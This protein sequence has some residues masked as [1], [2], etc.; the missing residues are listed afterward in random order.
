MLCE[1]PLASDAAEAQQMVDAFQQRDVLLAEAFMYR[2][3]PQIDR[4]KQ[5][6]A[7]GAVGQMQVMQGVF[8]FAISDE[9]NVRL[10]KELIGGALMDVGCYPVSLIRY[11]SG[12]EP[13][14]VSA[15][16][17]FGA[18]SGVDETLVGLLRFPGGVLAHFD[19]SLRAE[20]ANTFEVRGSTGR[21]LLERAYTPF[22]PDPNVASTI[23]YWH[24]GD[25][26]EIVIPPT[27][28]Y[29]LMAEDFADAL[30]NQRP[31]RF[32]IA[33]SIA[34]MRTL[35]QLYAAAGRQ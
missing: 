33:D 31:P 2:F 6:I 19:C 1:K 20:T 35:D 8:S 3:H 18:Q 26:E 34:Q 15:M 5:M 27:D 30:L 16:A 21:I 17:N 14:E 13:S 7:D 22:R 24:G 25:Y 9:T 4:L 10:N 32:S 23:R 29:T 12:E 11:V 28:P